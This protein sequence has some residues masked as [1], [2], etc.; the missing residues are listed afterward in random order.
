[1]PPSTNIEIH[2]P[3]LDIW[4]RALESSKGIRLLFETRDEA[5]HTQQRLYQARQAERRNNAKVYPQGHPLHGKS[6]YA[7]LMVRLK[8]DPP[9][10]EI[11]PA[12]AI[13]FELEEL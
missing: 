13:S 9:R 1:M 7:S 10:L 8:T 3:F 5:F 4:Q 12:E 2:Q 6:H 11:H